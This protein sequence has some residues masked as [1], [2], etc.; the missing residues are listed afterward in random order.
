LKDILTVKEFAEKEGISPTTVY[1]KIR[2]GELQSETHDGK[3]FVVSEISR[4]NDSQKVELF[5]PTDSE[6]IVNLQK[7]ISE[8]ENYTRLFENALEENMK[9]KEE[10]RELTKRVLKKVDKLEKK[11]EP[12]EVCEYL[13]ANGFTKILRERIAKDLANSTDSRVIK[14]DGKIYLDL[15]KYSFRDLIATDI[16]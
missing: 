7:R 15:S 5:T 13:I 14:K 6:K 9:L 12:V 3:K 1:K 16:H 2:S 10:N 8:L 11:K 4:E